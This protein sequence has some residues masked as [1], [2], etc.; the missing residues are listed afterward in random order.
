[1]NDA[2]GLSPNLPPIT[3]FNL[4]NFPILKKP[5]LRTPSE[6]VWPEGEKHFIKQIQ[7]NFSRQQYCVTNRFYDTF[8]VY[9]LYNPNLKC[10]HE[11]D[12]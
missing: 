4:S 10:L 6:S 3:L 7:E 9:P 5:I 2:Y 12:Q 11:R 1:M 8:V